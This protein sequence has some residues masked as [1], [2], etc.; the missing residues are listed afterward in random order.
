[1]TL[2]EFREKTKDMSDDAVIRADLELALTANSTI[3]DV[4]FVL[5]TEYRNIN[6]DIDS[7]DCVAEDD[8]V[9]SMIFL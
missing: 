7:I 4:D 3:C 5:P 2:R 1:M 9:L 8:I 6:L